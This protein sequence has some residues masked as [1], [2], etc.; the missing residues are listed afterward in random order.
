M[1]ANDIV[2]VSIDVTRPGLTRK[3][4]GTP[5]ILAYHTVWTDTRVR[6][7]SDIT[8]LSGDGFSSEDATYQ[9]ALALFSQSPRPETIKVGRKTRAFTQVIDLTPAAPASG[10]I[11]EIK[12]QDRLIRYTAGGG[13][14][15]SA[16]C[17]AIAAAINADTGLAADADAILATGGASSGS[18][19]TLTG[20]SLNGVVGIGSMV[21]ARALSMT[22]SNHA[23]WDATTAVIT[24]VDAAGNTIT[25]NFAIPNGGNTTVNGT[26]LFRRVTQIAIPAQSGAGGTFTVGTRSQATAVASG[27]TKVVV[28]ATLA[29]R[30]LSYH[31][32]TATVGI[33]DATSNPGVADD[34]TEV[35]TA[36][37][38]WYTLLLD[39]NSQAEIEALAPSIDA[40]EIMLVAQSAD[41]AILDSG[42]TTDVGYVLFNAARK[43]TAVF[44]H[45]SIGRTWLAAA[46][47]GNRSPADPGTD[48]W[49][50][51]QLTGVEAFDLQTTPLNAA[52]AK[53]VN[54]LRT[55][56]GATFT[57]KGTM[58]S[59][60]WIDIVRGTDWLYARMREDVLALKLANPKLP[61]TD[62]GI[63]A[64]GQTVLTV[65]E[66]ALPK[67]ESEPSLLA[68]D[69]RPSVTV[70]KASAV[71]STNRA[72]RVLPGVRFSARL[73]GAILSSQIAGTLYF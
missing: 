3:G 56:S 29:A 64:V 36:D 41:T 25:E 70:P 31:A 6:T 71:S 52:I 72:N 62:V 5:L 17:T 55:E 35:R 42:S 63:G 2:Q 38:D 53:K 40:L 47:T 8:E 69:P 4:F 20:A 10:K 19:Q 50:F 9:I 1:S 34:F 60:E 39:S 12:I 68:A 21:P 14:D 43:R 58:A 46:I 54:V 28:T 66:S 49:A 48:V 7:Y 26:K 33:K 16:V 11:Y 67:S 24:G 15:L 73:A 32:A 22:F 13:D 45:P 23:D 27:G 18:I 59:G 30:V 61:F 65:L 37:S 57:W 51:K 44:Y